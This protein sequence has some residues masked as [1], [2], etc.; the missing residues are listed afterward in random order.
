MR[1]ANTRVAKTVYSEEEAAGALGVSIEDFR[2]LV[3]THIIGSAGE[4][5]NFSAAIYAPSDLV[6]LR[7]LAKLPLAIQ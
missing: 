7:L 4:Q 6:V 2:Y 1:M 3:Q 5:Q